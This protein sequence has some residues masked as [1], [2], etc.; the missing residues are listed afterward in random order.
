VFRSENGKKTPFVR[1][2]IRRRCCFTGEDIFVAEHCES[3]WGSE[4]EAPLI[5]NLC[6]R[7]WCMVIFTPWRFCSSRKIPRCLFYS[8]LRGPVPLMKLL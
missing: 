8:R 3:A 7:R 2:S 1:P 6:A 5:L 4:G